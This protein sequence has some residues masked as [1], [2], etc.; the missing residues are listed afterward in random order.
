M[1][2]GHPFGGQFRSRPAAGMGHGG[3]CWLAAGTGTQ[4]KTPSKGLQRR[5]GRK[6][7]GA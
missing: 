6:K 1:C 7:E 3:Q 2:N 5:T 4:W